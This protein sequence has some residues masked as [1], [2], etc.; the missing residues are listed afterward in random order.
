M[1]SLNDDHDEDDDLLSPIP[2][3]DIER[4]QRLTE[5]RLSRCDTVL[6][7]ESSTEFERE[8]ARKEKKLYLEDIAAIKI[9]RAIS[10]NASLWIPSTTFWTTLAM[11][12]GVYLRRFR[13]QTGLGM[14][15]A[16]YLIVTVVFIW[17]SLENE[18]QSLDDG[19]GSM[20]SRELLTAAAGATMYTYIIIRTGPSY[21]QDDILVY[22]TSDGHQYLPR[23]STSAQLPPRCIDHINDFMA[24]NNVQY[25]AE[26]ARRKS[27]STSFW[28]D[29]SG[30]ESQICA[31][32]ADVFLSESHNY[33]F[34]P[35]SDSR[36]GELEDQRLLST[37][38]RKVPFH[39]VPPLRAMTISYLVIQNS[40]NNKFVLQKQGNPGTSQSLTI[41][42]E[43]NEE[44]IDCT[45]FFKDF[46]AHWELHHVTF[47]F[48][49]DSSSRN[50]EYVYDTD[51]LGLSYRVCFIHAN[52]KWI[53]DDQSDTFKQVDMDSLSRDISSSDK[54]VLTRAVKTLSGNGVSNSVRQPSMAI[55]NQRT[56]T[57]QG[58]PHAAG[59]SA[60][61]S[62]EQTEEG[63]DT[64]T[65]VMI[66]VAA[67]GVLSILCCAFIAIIG[68]MS[69]SQSGAT[70]A[71]DQEPVGPEEADESKPDEGLDQ[72]GK[73]DQAVP[74]ADQRHGA[75][76]MN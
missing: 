20:I 53:E 47:T 35:F 44:I 48:K 51:V 10:H 69:S 8:R 67:I 63:W 54:R 29:E 42:F 73:V 16:L 52:I 6:Q 11:K 49:G 19:M 57:S 9:E 26:P 66:T 36:F 68:I 45:Q 60:P 21:D 55:S 43:I 23:Q 7:S 76:A 61:A 22:I 12:S 75:T 17:T 74:S 18:D 15:L 72:K 37:V 56:F 33:K 58:D 14:A 64:S 1:L 41:P 34:V 4:I 32:N 13:W 40:R 70:E 38:S 2:M 50:V 24:I 28:K 39:P 27:I 25:H 62:P 30:T 71:V 46:L 59:R 31:M 3:K 65:I 5:Q